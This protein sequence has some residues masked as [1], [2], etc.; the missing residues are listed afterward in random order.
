MMINIKALLISICTMIFLGL[1]FELIFLFIDIGYNSLIKNYP[2]TESIRQPFYYLLI[3][4]GLFFIMFTGG[5]LT[6]IY[7]N[8]FVMV[9]TIVSGSVVCGL[10]L[11]ATSSGYE[12]TLLSGLFVIIGISFALYGNVVYKNNHHEHQYENSV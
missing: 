4:S 8:K 12:F 6:S 2:L 3:F 1:V 5:Y 9:H 11:Y 10:A 7:A